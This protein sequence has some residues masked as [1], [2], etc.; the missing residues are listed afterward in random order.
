VAVERVRD[1]E[2]ADRDA[3]ERDDDRDGEA[4]DERPD[5]ELTL[6]EAYFRSPAA[7]HEAT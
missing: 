7:A 3:V 2:D 4:R 5:D 1:D 6:I